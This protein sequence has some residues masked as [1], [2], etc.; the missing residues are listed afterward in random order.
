[1]VAACE[2]LKAAGYPIALDDFV[3]NDPRQ[4]LAALADIIKVD[5]ERTTP[6]KALPWSS[7]YGGPRCRMLAE[8]VET[9]EQ[10]QTAQ[11]AGFVYFQGYF[12]RRPEVLKTAEIPANQVNYLRMLEGGLAA[13]AWTSRAGRAD[14]ERGFGAAIVCCDT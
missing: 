13:G 10:F 14:Q 8:K 4:P 5:F 1:M 9:R 6:S 11:N 12:F 3:A 2:R 7:V